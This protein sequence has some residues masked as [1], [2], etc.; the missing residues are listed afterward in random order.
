MC[1]SDLELP[2]FNLGVEAGQLAIVAVF[3]PP[4]FAWRN[5]WVYRELTFRFGSVVIVLLAATWMVERVFAIKV[6]PF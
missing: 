1:S 6:L 4:A 3:V 5:S 2:C